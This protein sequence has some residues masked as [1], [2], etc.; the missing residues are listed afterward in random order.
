MPLD[1]VTEAHARK[2]MNKQ[3]ELLR[4]GTE[5]LHLHLLRVTFQ[6]AVDQ[7]LFPYNPFKS[8]NP[9][10]KICFNALLMIDQVLI[11]PHPPSTAKNPLHFFPSRRKKT[12]NPLPG[13]PGSFSSNFPS[14][15]EMALSLS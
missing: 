8:V 13:K 12:A 9:C 5:R 7:R 3:L 4:S 14:M 1:A 10:T 11:L 15:S 6:Q 2:F